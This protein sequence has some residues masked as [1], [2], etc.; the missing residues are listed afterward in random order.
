MGRSFAHFGI[1]ALHL[2]VGE[3][4]LGAFLIL[5]PRAGEHRWPWA[6]LHQPELRNL[7]IAYLIFLGWGIFE[8]AR[9]IFTGYP[10]LNSVRDLSVNYYPLFFFLG[11]W[12][13]IQYKNYLQKFIRVVA[14]TNGIYGILF[15]VLLTRLAWYY[16]SGFD[17]VDSY[18]PVSL[19]GQPSFSA[20]ILLGLLSFEKNLGRV[21]IPLALNAFVLVS[22]LIR[23]EWLAFA[24]GLLLWLWFTKNLK[25]AALCGGILVGI[26]AFMYFVNFTF[27]GA[28]TRGG[29]ISA[30]DIIGR[31]IA[32]VNP[33]LAKEYTADVEQYGGTA[34]WRTLFW[35]EI[36]SSVHESKTRALFGYGYG[37]PLFDLLP[38]LVDPS[39]RS[40]HNVFILFLGYTGWIG[41]A[42]FAFFQAMLF[43]LLWATYKAT[44]QP[45]GV[46]FWF[47]MLAFAGFTPFFETPFGA[48]PFFLVT[49]CACAPLFH[50]S[51]A[52]EPATVLKP[53]PAAGRRATVRPIGPLPSPIGL[54]GSR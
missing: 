32:P 44:G 37:Y 40:P 30:T 3:M 9:G 23:A 35:F 22:M 50:G 7:R 27:E 36:W 1:P 16:P 11:L 28:E 53:K 15:I 14:W 18:N 4:A 10:A 17:A 8:T 49:G 12:A 41:V 42:I 25:R 39:T 24:L 34:A 26:L 51:K 20:V 46:I 2:F 38:D 21:A 43:R 52:A 33:D 19:F 47:T 54:E 45:Y 5:G 29:T 6:A 48:I 31:A 13:G